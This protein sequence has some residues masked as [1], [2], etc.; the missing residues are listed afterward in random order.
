MTL[1]NEIYLIYN[2]RSN[3]R[4]LFFLF[5]HRLCMIFR[6][7]KV[8]KFSKLLSI[9]GVFF[10]SKQEIPN[11]NTHC[12][13]RNKYD[14]NRSSDKK[15]LERVSISYTCYLP[16]VGSFRYDHAVFR[17]VQDATTQQRIIH[18]LRLLLLL[19]L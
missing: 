7:I 9:G 13:P 16:D 12:Y 10:F 2:G 18:L 4:S 3:E 17:P 14:A 15:F 19:F 6:A 1:R 5:Q 11:D 8:H